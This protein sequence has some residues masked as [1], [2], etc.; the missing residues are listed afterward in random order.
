MP[1]R[2][3]DLLLEVADAAGDIAKSF[4]GNGP[5]SWDKGDGQGPVTE[6]DLAIDAMLKERLLAARPDYGW[7]SEET[8]DD[9]AR[10][11]KRDVFIID[12]IDGTRAFIEGSKN[13]SHALAVVRHGVV[14]AAVVHLPLLG[15]TFAATLGGGAT[16]NGAPIK[17]G[18]RQELAG[19]QTLVAKPVLAPSLWP[20]GVPPVERRFRSSLAYRLCLIADGSFDAM[21]TLRDAWEWDIAA[22]TLI[23][24]EAGALVS[25]RENETLM[26]NNP[27]PKLPGVL[28]A[29]EGL[30]AGLMTHLK[31]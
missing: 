22:G 5:Q 2:D 17:V 26:F 3:L 28:V 7:L 1:E 9:T 6:A 8:E 30:H 19:A 13:F 11:S 18:P 25:D 29:N 24:L 14:T 20:G 27:T 23:A 4:F 21:I 15:D 10:L 12:P 31:P 16:L